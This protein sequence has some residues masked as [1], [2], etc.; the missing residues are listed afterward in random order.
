LI[1]IFN[2]SHSSPKAIQTY[3]GHAYEVLDI[4]VSSDNSRFASVGGDKTVFLWDVARAEVLKR[5]SG[6]SGRCNAVVLGGEDDS[7]VI[8]GNTSAC[9]SEVG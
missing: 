4:A 3:Q 5:F 6:H 1:R 9:T 2:P 8:S 7:V